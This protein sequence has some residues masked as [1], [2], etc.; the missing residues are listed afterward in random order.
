[1][2]ATNYPKSFSHI[3]ITVP[4]IQKAVDFYEGVMGWY[5]IM[6]P[7]LFKK[8]LNSEFKMNEFGDLSEEDQLL[9]QTLL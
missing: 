8:E 9:Q 5:I 6:P 7:S 3:G 4:D 1:M 2:K